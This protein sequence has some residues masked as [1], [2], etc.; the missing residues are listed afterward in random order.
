MYDFRIDLVAEWIT[1]KGANTVALQMPEGLKVHAQSIAGEIEERTGVRC[2]I[3]ADPCYGA[4]DVDRR[5]TDYADVLVQFGHADIP[6]MHAGPNV[7]FVEVFMDMDISALL[8]GAPALK[9]TVGVLTTVQHEML[10]HSRWLEDNGHPALWEGERRPH[11]I[12][13]Q[14]LDETSPP[15]SRSRAV[16]QLPLCRQ[17]Q[18]PPAES[19]HETPCRWS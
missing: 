11:R 6:S 14:V 7:L 19:G 16:R 2:V 12:R 3:V 8:P 10:H 17:R 15:W 13:G 5:F 4:C 1:G 18:L 9:G